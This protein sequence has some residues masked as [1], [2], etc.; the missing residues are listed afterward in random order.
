M[1]QR[2]EG[3]LTARDETSAQQRYT[4]LGCAVCR[5][6]PHGDGEDDGIMLWNPYAYV[7]WAAVAIGRRHDCPVPLP[8]GKKDIQ[9]AAAGSLTKPYRT[10]DIA[11]YM[12]AI[13]QQASIRRQDLSYLY[14]KT[15]FSRGK[16]DAASY[17][18]LI[19]VCNKPKST[20]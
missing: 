4:Q 11:V 20:E 1:K 15:R 12:D 3:L 19:M 10:P 14:S 17:C 13:D 9:L 6:R 18:Q 2:K 7:C 5:N 8:T 16:D